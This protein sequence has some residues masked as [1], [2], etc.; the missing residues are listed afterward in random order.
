MNKEEQKILQQAEEEAAEIISIINNGK[1]EFVKG[2]PDLTF[3][4]LLDL[5]SLIRVNTRYMLFD[6]EAS[7]REFHQLVE[8]N[9]ALAKQLKDAEG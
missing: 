2:P 8:E 7:R 3:K 6:I 1:V 4:A 5:I 9:K